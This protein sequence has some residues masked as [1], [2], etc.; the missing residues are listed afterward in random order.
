M[1][2]NI[3]IVVSALIVLA[4][5]VTAYFDHQAGAEGIMWF[6]IDPGLLM[7]VSLWILPESKKDASTP[8]QEDTSETP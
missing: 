7:A 8:A 6:V 5:L 4:S 3:K 2:A 1:P